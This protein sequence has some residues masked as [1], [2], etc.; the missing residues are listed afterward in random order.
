MY[1]HLHK[2]IKPLTTQPRL[3]KS[4]F[5]AKNSHC[6]SI[7]SS[8]FVGAVSSSVQRN[9][10]HPIWHVDGMH[11]VA[12]WESRSGPLICGRKNLFIKFQESACLKIHE[13]SPDLRTSNSHGAN[14]MINQ[15]IYRY[16]HTQDFNT[17]THCWSFLNAHVS[18]HVLNDSALS[19][20]VSY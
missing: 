4:L 5:P 10:V 3:T 16:T 2:R 15:W 8:F 6:F 1:P 12:S 14:Q 20:S 18:Y 13:N 19:F 17:H 7:N 9:V 11:L